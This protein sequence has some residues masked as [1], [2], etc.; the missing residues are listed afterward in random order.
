MYQPYPSGGRMPERE[1]PA[2]PRAM[3]TAVK[4]MYAGAVLSALSLIAA[5]ATVGDLKS[6]IERAAPTLTPQQV[7]SAETITVV[8]AVISGLIG[9]GLW[10]WM[11]WANKEG[12]KWARIV[13][14]V[15]FGLDTLRVLLGLGRAGAPVSKAAEIVVWLVGLGVIVLIWRGESSA[16]YGASR[17]P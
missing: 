13:A 12:K 3:Q 14:T 2:P 6:A 16:F 4:L 7:N 5:L 8:L 15:L 17:R 9:V 1:R 10:L 11:A